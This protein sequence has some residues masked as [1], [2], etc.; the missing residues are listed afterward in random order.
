MKINFKIVTP[1]RTVYEA[2]ADQITLPTWEG[3]IT[4]LPN[5]YSYISNLKAG[6]IMVKHDEHTELMAT[7]GGFVEFNNNS[8]VVLADTAERAEE[9]DLE[10]AEA[11]RKKA[12]EYKKGVIHDDRLQYALAAEIQK[13]LARVRV[14]MK[15]RRL[16]GIQMPQNNG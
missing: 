10:R 13:E 2:K 8:L 7:S 4:I 15:H 14:V 5:H 1:E 11:A 6:E 3:E 9:I 12:E 16:R